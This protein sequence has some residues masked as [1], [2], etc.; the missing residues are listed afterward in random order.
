MACF[1]L[2]YQKYLE[3]FKKNWVID[4]V[5]EDGFVAI[6]MIANRADIDPYKELIVLNRLFGKCKISD[7]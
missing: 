2:L 3:T 5:R 4:I 7:Y 1:N 6:K